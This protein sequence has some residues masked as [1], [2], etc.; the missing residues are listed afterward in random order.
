VEGARGVDVVLLDSAGGE[1][2][3]S[4]AGDLDYSEREDRW[5]F[6]FSA[7]AAPGAPI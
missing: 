1:C 7:L 2:G 3:G 4:G 5:K 6:L